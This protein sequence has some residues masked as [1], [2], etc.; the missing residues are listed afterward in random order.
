MIHSLDDSKRVNPLAKTTRIIAKTNLAG[1]LLAILA[2]ALILSAPALAETG[3]PQDACSPAHHDEACCMDAGSDA[4]RPAM[5]S[6]PA[7][8]AHSCEDSGCAM[9]A[10]CAAPVL[11]LPPQQNEASERLASRDEP[12]RLADSRAS[13]ALDGLKRPPRA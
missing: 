1:F 3:H 8:A 9:M 11:A 4:V 12:A 5:A 10:S 2:F 6:D 13:A 7:D